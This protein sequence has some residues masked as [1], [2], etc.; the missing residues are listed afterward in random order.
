ML[1][2]RLLSAMG[3]APANYI[4][5]VFSTYLYTGTGATRTITNGI[6][7]AGKGGLT[8]IKQRTLTRDHNLFD[9]NRGATKSL[10][11][12]STSGEIT[13]TTTLTSFNSNGFSLGDDSDTFG[14]NLNSQTYAS[15]TF[16][17]QP[18][19]FDV[20][21]Y[22]GNGTVKTV[23]HNLGS[24]PGV[25]I[26]KCTSAAGENWAVYHR[27]L[28]ATKYLELN[29]TNAASTSVGSRWDA[30][31]TSTSFSVGYNGSVN[32]SGE[33]YV[34]YLFA[35]D[36]G[37]F[38]LTGTDNVISCG[39]YTGNGT[40]LQ[41]I[42]L[43]YEP[44]L[45]L[46]K[47]ASIAGTEWAML[48]NMRGVA[49]GGV[50]AVLN[51]NT[52]GAEASP[53]D[54]VDFTSTGFNLKTSSSI[55]NETGTYIYIAIRRGPMRVPTS[56]TSV[57]AP[58]AR[59]GTGSATT[60][61]ASIT[62]DL[63]IIKQ[64]NAVN[65]PSFEDRLRGATKIL[66][67]SGTGAEA[68]NANYI[69]S[70]AVQTGYSLGTSS[71]V[72]SG[73][74]TYADWVFKRAPSFFDVVCYTGTGSAGQTFAHNLGVVP[75]LMIVKCRSNAS[76]SWRV[77]YQP[78][79]IVGQLESTA[80]VVTTNREFYFGDDTN[81]IS[82]TASVFTVASNSS[83]NTSARTYVAY[84][85]ATCAGVSKV[86]SYT[87]TDA[88]QTINCGFSSG[89]R[90]VLIKKTNGTSNWYVWD[91]A[92]GMVSGT[93]PSLRLNSN[94]AEQNSDDVFAIAGGFQLVSAAGEINGLGDTY[95]YL[96]IA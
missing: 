62:T 14:V 80:T 26:V 28:G 64:R 17:E 5:D 71:G 89:A 31:P 93:D 87:G 69:S 32:S 18:K 82:P 7:L 61:D 23:N 55:Y 56:G 74:G 4:E 94:L 92:R 59:S 1:K 53:Y 20:V 29:N 60:V 21:T 34:A 42:N 39:S 79:G 49:T 33:T 37:G 66:E 16:R 72:N 70:F 91:S 96:A 88:T 47:S 6:D 65:T 83:V 46:I 15:W 35:H 43:G 19:F 41:S 40:S 24:V 48:D 13:G 11:S 30:E 9:T 22:T 51:P 81:Y 90:F 95:I 25:M 2:N 45:V 76:S 8:W 36:A 44:Q 3:G 57:F 10:F 50:D 67:S 85:F 52:S 84:L 68:T 86:G 38:G 12:D 27:S 54:R 63:A 73:S 58:I 78:T 75:E 77:L